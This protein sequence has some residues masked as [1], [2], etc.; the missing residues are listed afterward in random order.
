M[1]KNR[2]EEAVVSLKWFRG[3]ENIDGFDESPKIIIDEMKSIVVTSSEN[4]TFSF[5]QN[6]KNLL[7][8]R[9]SLKS[10]LVLMFLVVL[11][12]MSGGSVITFFA[13]N[14]FSR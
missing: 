6:V 10:L 9:Q 5:R 8:N 7:T 2:P 1:C 13:F 3:V 11:I 4:S 12:P 14:I